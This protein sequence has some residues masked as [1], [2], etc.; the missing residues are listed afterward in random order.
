MAQ[1][2]RRKTNVVILCTM[3]VTAA[4]MECQQIKNKLHSCDRFV[5]T[6]EKYSDL[7]EMTFDDEEEEFLVTFFLANQPPK[8][9]RDIG[10][11]KRKKCT[12]VFTFAIFR[13]K[14][15]KHNSHFLHPPSFNS[16]AAQGAPIS[17]VCYYTD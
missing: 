16:S 5:R 15:Y 13:Q 2:L 11:C 6:S 17:M 7:M 8:V 3:L 1:L 14:L 4:N 10:R 9:N 12:N